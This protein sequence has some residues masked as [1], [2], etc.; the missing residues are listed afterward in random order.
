VQRALLD[1][2][3]LS[4]VMRGHNQGVAQRAAAYLSTHGRFSFSLIT[5]YEVLRGLK[6]R[7]A[8]G[9]LQRFEQQCGQSEVLSLNDDVIVQAS[10]VYT[11]LYQRGLLIS[12]ADILIGAT[13]LYYGLPLISDNARHFSRIPGLIVQSW[14]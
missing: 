4:E 7:G 13:A 6:A 14:R 8:V 2:S 9:Q 10:E 5:R 3:T 12:D 11:D 1:T